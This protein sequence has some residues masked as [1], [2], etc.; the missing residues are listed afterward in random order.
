VNTRPQPVQAR[1]V[2]RQ[3]GQA[4]SLPLNVLPHPVQVRSVLWQA[5][6]ALCVP[7]NV[8]PHPVQVRS[9]ARQA[10]QRVLPPDLNVVPHSAQ[11]WSL[12]PIGQAPLRWVAAAV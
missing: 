9:V 11:T 10:E 1:L 4:R 3:A 6:H 7:W 8:L 12:V 5:L 2:T